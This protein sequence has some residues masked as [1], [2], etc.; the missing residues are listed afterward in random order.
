MGEFDG[1][2]SAQRPETTTGDLVPD[3]A[4]AGMP[5][6]CGNDG[7]A[8]ASGPAESPLARKRRDRDEAIDRLMTEAK[9]RGQTADRA[10]WSMVYDFELAPMST[11]RKQLKEL[12]MEVPPSASLTDDALTVQ[13]Q[14]VIGMLAE[15]NIYLLHTDHLSDRELYER[16]ERDILDEE[17]RDLPPDGN[18]R[19]FIDLCIS[20]SGDDQ[21]VFERYYCGGP[22]ALKP[23]Y[24]RDSGLPRPTGW[25]R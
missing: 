25:I 11:N 23:P 9:G 22:S 3:L 12:G 6:P 20:G 18:A 2:E 21:E 8:S 17:V 5:R 10:F 15:M 19:E 24:D 13:L 16:L 4:K 1:R 14:A 7:E